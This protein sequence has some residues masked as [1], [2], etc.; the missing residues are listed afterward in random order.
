MK[1]ITSLDSRFKKSNERG[2]RRTKVHWDLIASVEYRQLIQLYGEIREMAPPPYGLMEKG[3]EVTID[4][5]EKLLH[6]LYQVGKEGLNIQRYKGLG[7]M[8]PDT[9]LG[10]DHEPGNP[11]PPQG[12][13]G[14]CRRGR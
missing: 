10:D 13:G 8:N 1:N 5:E 12:E 9:T 4:S 14:R 6:S 3:R 2:E 7:E 11:D